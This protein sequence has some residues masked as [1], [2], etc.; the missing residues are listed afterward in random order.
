MS[1][2]LYMAHLILKNLTHCFFSVFK[3]LNESFLDAFLS[4]GYSRKQKKKMKCPYIWSNL[5]TWAWLISVI[6]WMMDALGMTRILEIG[7]HSWDAARPRKVG[8]SIGFDPGLCLIEMRN[9]GQN[10]MFM[11]CKWILYET[12]TLKKILFCN[13]KI[14]IFVLF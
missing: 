10:P 6:C 9:S 2:Y 12:I 5:G 3:Q 7:P 1:L 14:H 11:Y 13:S 4:F 8:L